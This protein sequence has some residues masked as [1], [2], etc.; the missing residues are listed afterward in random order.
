MDVLAIICIGIFALFLID[1]GFT[2]GT[3]IGVLVI[4]EVLIAMFRIHEHVS[5]KTT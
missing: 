2:R 4:L 1:A 5:V 3:A